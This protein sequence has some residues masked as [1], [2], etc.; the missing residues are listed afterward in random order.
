MA[1]RHDAFLSYSHSADSKIAPPFQ[2]GLEKIAKPLL[3]RRALDVFRDQTSLSASPALWPGIVAHLS[4]S[5]WFLL[6]A[7]PASAASVWCTKE[8]E[9]WLEN[10]SGSRMLILL[11]E[12]EIF[13][14]AKARD[15]DWHRTTAISRVLEGRLP[16]EPLY[17]DLRWARDAETLSLRNPRF[18]DAVVSV[19]APLRGMRKDDL[20]GA[21]LRQLAR[22]R[23]LVRGGITAI[24]IFAAVAVWQAIVAHQQR[25]EA[26]RQRD[27]ALAR[28]L[29]AQAELMRV[30]Q[31]ERLPLA[32]LMSAESTRM[33]ADSIETQQ[34]LQ[35]VLAQFPSSKAVFPH[36]SAVTA[37][38]LSPD[39]RQVATAASD[40]AGALWQLSDATRQASLP[41]A[42]RIVIY[43]PD[44]ER[45]GACCKRVG[46]WTRTGVEVLGFSPQDLMGNPQTIAFSPDGRLLAVG[47]LGSHPGFAVFDIDTKQPVLRH[48]SELSGHATAISFAPNGD[49]V[50]AL[51]DKVDIYAGGTWHLARTLAPETGAILRVATSPNGRYLAAG[52]VGKVTVFDLERGSVA[53]RLELRGDGPGQLNRLGFDAKGAHLGAVG[54]LNSGAIWRVGSWRESVAVRH[55]ELQTIHSLSFDPAQPEAVSCGTDG[56]CI[57]WSLATGRRV[58]QFAHLHAY[59]GAADVQRQM[60]SGAFGAGKSLF[61]SG[62]ADRNATVW[63]LTRAGELAHSACATEDVLVRPFAPMGRS[64]SSAAGGHLEL[65]PQGCGVT[66]AADTKLGSVVLD[67]TG[68]FAAAD[69]PVDVA[70]VWDTA[71]GKVLAILAHTDPVDWEAVLARLKAQGMGVRASQ[72]EMAIM[73]ERGRLRVIAASAS[74]K[75]VATV[76]AADRTLR[77]W[78][79]P[80][81]QVIYSE[82]LTK[83]VPVL[84][85]L[86]DASALRVDGPGGLSAITLPGGAPAWSVNLGRITALAVSA[87]GRWIAAAATSDRRSAVRLFETATGQPALERQTEAPVGG[88]AFDRASRYVVALL[89]EHTAVPTGLPM[90]VAL[91]VWERA[92]GR[93]LLALPK[94]DQIIALDFSRDGDHFAAVGAGGEVR[95]WNLATGTSRRTVTSD[96]GPLAFSASGRWI[97]VGTRSVRILD[98][99]TLRPVA[100]LDLGGDIRGIQFRSDDRVIAVDRFAPGETPGVTQEQHWLAADLLAEA[101][102]RLPVATAES[103]WRQLF[104]GHPVPSPCSYETPGNSR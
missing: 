8:I 15:F 9:W 76:R 13:W 3:K 97:A 47:V 51:R 55:A 43:A 28:Q 93:A 87:D 27:I 18:R 67:P 78:D 46:V 70:R 31:P 60:L 88:L 89:G 59:T 79:V 77:V 32:L 63:D 10:R 12:G 20:D 29:A 71:S 25:I 38:A 26:E 22:N 69:T 1:V 92:S 94:S 98:A 48:Q 82:A 6:L 45:I 41:G 80:S 33:H 5:E 72:S 86:S 85:F 2:H 58:H 68:S 96:P 54:E 36:S 100:Q 99:S 83:H 16:D 74:G 101:C 30:Q 44:G 11:T 65:V 56:Y 24:I 75:R 35:S 4:A 64:W 42:D 17:V 19:A 39:L 49:L 90:G 66:P 91:N 102:R 104:P 7:S 53:A 14:D 81:G 103:Q 62:G 57:G 23:R 34:T 21:D 61:V 95:L 40:G 50:V 84:E 73:K 52:A 37:A